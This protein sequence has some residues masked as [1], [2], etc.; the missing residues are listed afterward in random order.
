MPS[1]LVVVDGKEYVQQLGLKHSRVAELWLAGRALETIADDEG[2]KFDT[3]HKYMQEIKGL[4]RRDVKDVA[5]ARAELVATCRL[6]RQWA[7]RY[8]Q[9]AKR[10]SDKVGF[11][12]LALSAVNTELEARGLKQLTVNVMSEQCTQALARLGEAGRPRGGGEVPALGA[13]QLGVI[14]VEVREIQ[15]A[16]QCRL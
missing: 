14:D 16:E 5:S 15:K 1:D 8:V 13:G 2:L 10:A 4:W 7:V 6:V 3:V 12:K 11:G 9:L